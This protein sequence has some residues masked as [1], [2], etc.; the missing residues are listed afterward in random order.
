MADKP[1][2]KKELTIG[3]VVLI[4]LIAVF[5]FIM[6]PRRYSMKDGGTVYY[7]SWP[8]YITYSVQRVHELVQENNRKYFRKG[9]RIRIFE[10]VV[11]EDT[12]VD[13]DHPEPT[14]HSPEYYEASRQLESAM[15]SWKSNSQV[16]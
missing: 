6:F 13:Y 12:Y 2:K 11:Y 7:G 8:A 10:N 9:I 16:S 15:D 14:G 5:V 4:I 1:E 3:K